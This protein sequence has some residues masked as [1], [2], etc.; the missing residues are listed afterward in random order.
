MVVTTSFHSSD[1]AGS[2]RRSLKE[3]GYESLI[4]RLRENYADITNLFAAWG[5]P[6]Q[7]STTPL[8]FLIPDPL[9]AASFI[10]NYL[11]SILSLPYIPESPAD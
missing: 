6:R 7:L 5:L 3:R 2:T 1:L 4:H 9:I 8:N 11:I 10:S